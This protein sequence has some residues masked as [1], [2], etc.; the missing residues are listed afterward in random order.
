MGSFAKVESDWL[1]PQ[2]RPPRVL[3]N[4]ELCAENICVGDAFLE[5]DGLML[6]TDCLDGLSAREMALD[7]L[8]NKIT[9]A[10]EKGLF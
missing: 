2:Q 6:C 8:N 9:I 10:G 1:E 5:I 3:Y 7:V 4:C